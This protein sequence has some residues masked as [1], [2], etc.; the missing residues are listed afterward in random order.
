[1]RCTATRVPT[2]GFGATLSAH[3][4]VWG[5]TLAGLA[6]TS[7][8]AATRF[9]TILVESDSAIPPRQSASASFYRIN[10]NAARKCSVVPVGAQLAA[11]R[12]W[13]CTDYLAP[14]P[15]EISLLSAGA[16]SVSGTRAELQLQEGDLGSYTWNNTL[17]APLWGGGELLNVTLD[18]SEAFPGATLGVLAPYPIA[19]SAPI[20]PADGWSL[21]SQEDL[22]LTWS[23]A[24]GNDVDVA[25]S[26][27]VADPGGQKDVLFPALDCTFPGDDG[28]GVIPASLLGAVA[29]PAGLVGHDVSVLTLSI[30]SVQIADA[31]LEFRASS[32]GLSALATIQ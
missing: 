9:G 30:A 19:V 20:V 29:R 3:S 27:V 31:L 4:L 10:S 12:L 23:G 2:E 24:M 28:G 21:D 16:V 22:E 26:I 15:D 7:G 25:I 1:M 32:S 8:S 6:C 17:N 14:T 18:G 5:L 11:C 13:E